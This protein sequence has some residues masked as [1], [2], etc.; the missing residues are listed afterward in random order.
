MLTDLQNALG[1][2]WIPT[3]TAKDEAKLRL[4]KKAA[5]RVANGTPTYLVYTRQDDVE[6]LG[7]IYQ[8][9]EA[10]RMAANPNLPGEW[11]TALGI[12]EPTE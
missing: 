11:F 2:I 3:L 10:K 7:H 8:G 5:R 6:Y 12:T 4:I 9:D 1:T